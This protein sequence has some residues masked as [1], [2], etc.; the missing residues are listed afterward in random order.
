MLGEINSKNPNSI[1]DNII[2]LSKSFEEL[3]GYLKT[4]KSIVDHGEDAKN[5]LFNLDFQYFKKVLDY[6]KQEQEKE[7]K[8]NEKEEE[9]KEDKQQ[10]FWEFIKDK[11]YNRDDIQGI[12]SAS[13]SLD[14]IKNN[15]KSLDD[16]VKIDQCKIYCQENKTSFW[17]LFTN[18]RNNIS[19]IFSLFQKNK[20][21]NAKKNKNV[22]SGQSLKY[23]ASEL[24]KDDDEG[25]NARIMFYS[26]SKNMSTEDR[27]KLWKDVNKYMSTKEEAKPKNSENQDMKVSTK[28]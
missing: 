2:C 4:I 21:Q 3:D 18:M 7:K 19:K 10:S 6:F 16:T 17:N 24:D 1:L 13:N 15:F 23:I 25:E 20:N 26:M 22:S 28:S 5:F 9:K 12:V 27:Q 14:E 11:K 8:E